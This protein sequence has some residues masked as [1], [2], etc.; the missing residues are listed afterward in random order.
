MNRRD[1]LGDNVNRRTANVLG[2]AIVLTTVGLGT[3]QLLK[4]FGWN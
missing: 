4:V 1:L 2:G 3:I